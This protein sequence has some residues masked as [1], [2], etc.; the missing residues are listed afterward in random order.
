MRIFSFFP[1]I[2]TSWLKNND[3]ARWILWNSTQDMMMGWNIFMQAYIKGWKALAGM[4]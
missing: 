4:R 1:P 3:R 2:K